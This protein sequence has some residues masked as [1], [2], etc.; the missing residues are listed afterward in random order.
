[1][2]SF[3]RVSRSEG[4]SVIGVCDGGAVCGRHRAAGL[5]GRYGEVSGRISV[6]RLKKLERSLADLAVQV[7]ALDERVSYFLDQ[8]VAD[9]EVACGGADGADGVDVGVDTVPAGGEAETWIME[10]KLTAPPRVS[11]EMLRKSLQC[12]F[13]R[14]RAE[15]YDAELDPNVGMVSGQSGELESRAAEG[16]QKILY[17][18]PADGSYESDG[19][20]R[21]RVGRGDCE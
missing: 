13:D 10:T 5:A 3:G 20:C 21:C 1:M 9:A 15:C 8:G 7:K 4:K 14:L 18:E 12:M 11:G 6:E 17:S 2:G 16:A 19:S